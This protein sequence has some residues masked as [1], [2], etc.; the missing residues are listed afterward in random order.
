VDGWG[1][2]TERERAQ[3]VQELTRGLSARH[4][5]AI[6]TYFRKLNEPTKRP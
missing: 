3:A 2:M 6:A 4:R 5:E 1:K